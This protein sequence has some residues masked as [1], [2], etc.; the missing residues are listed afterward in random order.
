MRGEQLFQ[1]GAALVQRLLAQVLAVQLQQVVGLHARGRVG[2]R[3]GAGLATLDARLQR[4]EGQR[5]VLAG[6]PGQQLAVD[7]AVARQCGRGRFDLREA[8]VQALLAARPQRHLAVAADQLQADAVPLPFQAP[9]A[10][11]AQRSDLGLQWRGQKERIRLLAIARQLLVGKQILQEL[12]RWRP[13]PSMRWAMRAMSMPLISASACCTSR[14]DTP[15][16]SAPVSS[17]LN[18]SR[19]A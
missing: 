15:T 1:Q 11:V 8:A 13:G 19:C 5:R 14:C 4:G 2:Q 9:V 3:L 12:R 18:T 16:R 10:D 7:H 6:A 17:L